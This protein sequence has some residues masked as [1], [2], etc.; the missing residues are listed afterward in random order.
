LAWM[1]AALRRVGVG[2]D[3]WLVSSARNR[4]ASMQRFDGAWVS[5]DGEAFDIHTIL[6]ALRGLL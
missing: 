2:V 4:L 3:D 1:I 6:T 5:D